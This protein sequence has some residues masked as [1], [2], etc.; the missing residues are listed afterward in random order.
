M[1]EHKCHAKGC[2]V[3]VPPKRLFCLK[4]WRMTPRHLQLEVWRH[5]RPGQE[6]DKN[7]SPVYL[8]VMK[9]AIEAVST[10]EER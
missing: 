1:S 10:R 2:D 9:R 5:Y 7:P 4:H 8:D 3:A 6:I